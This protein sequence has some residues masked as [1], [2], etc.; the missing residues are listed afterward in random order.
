MTYLKEKFKTSTYIDSA[1]ERYHTAARIPDPGAKGML[2]RY[3]THLVSSRDGSFT[4]EHYRALVLPALGLKLFGYSKPIV[5]V[6]IMNAL[7]ST[8]CPTDVLAAA[9]RC[10]T[11]EYR[12]AAALNPSCL[13]ED[14]V[15]AALL[16]YHV[17]GVYA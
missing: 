3:L 7:K 8:E 1:I 12:R 16:G 6:V 14:R 4:P 15:Y 13:E 9:S 17:A 11:E 10:K 5:F 2:T